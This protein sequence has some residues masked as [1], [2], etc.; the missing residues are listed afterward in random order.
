[1]AWQPNSESLSQLAAC[2]KDSLSGF[3][4]A[5]QKQAEIV[6]LHVLLAGSLTLLRIIILPCSR[7]NCAILIRSLLSD[8]YPSQVVARYQ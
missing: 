2:L 6:R 3:N 4:K 7:E 5:A 1:M 8:A